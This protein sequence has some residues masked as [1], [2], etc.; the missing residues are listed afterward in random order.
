MT[1]EGDAAECGG[2]PVDLDLVVFLEDSE[3]VIGVVL[4][5]IFHGEVVDDEDKGDRFCGCGAIGWVCGGKDRNR[6]AGGGRGVGCWLVSLIGGGH[7][8]PL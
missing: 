8:C 2:R 1:V 4:V 6:G 3:E 7:T 5:D